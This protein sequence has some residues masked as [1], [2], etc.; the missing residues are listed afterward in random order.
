M[1]R[2][3]TYPLAALA[4]LL[5]VFLS[6]RHAA[7]A[8]Q[9]QSL[10]NAIEGQ[11]RG[12][13]HEGFAQPIPANPQ[14]PL[15][16]PQ[17]PPDPVPE[18]PPDVRPEG[19]NVQWIPGYWAWDA[20][21]NQFLWV[22]GVW[23][24]AP[25]GQ[26]YVP[27]YWVQD[28]DSWRWV[29]GF[30]TDGS[31][32]ELSYDPPPPDSLENGP[33]V[34]PPDDGSVYSPGTWVYQQTRFAWRP[35]YWM[36]AQPGMVW[37]PAHY[38]WTP[39]GFVLVPGYWDYPLEERGLLF[40]PVVFNQP[41][42]EQA[43]WVYRPAY[44]VEPAPLLRSLFIGPRW[45]SYYF[46]NSYRRLGPRGGFL[47]WIDLGPRRFDPLLSYYRFRNRNNPAWTAGLPPRTLVQPLAQINRQAL[48]LT[49][50]TATQRTAQL[51]A[52]T[53]L[54]ETVV[55]RRRVEALA[56]RPRGVTGATVGR[57]TLKLNTTAI[58]LGA[59]TVRSTEIKRSSTTVVRPPARP[60]VDVRK[61]TTIDRRAEKV[62]RP[63]HH[64]PPPA[65]TISAARPVPPPTVAARATA[66]SH[67]RTATST[68]KVARPLS[69]QVQT[70]KASVTV[71]RPAT[72]VHAH[73]AA[74]ARANGPPARVHTPAP[75][76]PSGASN[77]SGQH[78]NHAHHK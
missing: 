78:D 54:R 47:P 30:W 56:V 19:G 67:V 21:Q 73:A 45:T 27:G 13:V 20:E 64:T 62:A 4:A 48:R 24:N 8:Q 42:W 23:R 46:G 40:A 16:I 52:A 58:R 9:E 15:A 69:H 68:A 10:P 6:Q 29:S 12:P 61:A 75:R 25:P 65:K 14:P 63:V 70:A 53:R 36:A 51:A 41:L 44:V 71:S 34:P 74:V 2:T 38:A 33:S 32:G 1:L 18:E 76:P 50:L 17:Q 26:T 28:G 59:T 72:V 37:V 57:A 11:A 35:G 31:R 60:A 77:R 5:A 7:R 55:A 43:G 39:A 3:G 66:V 22:S 49:T